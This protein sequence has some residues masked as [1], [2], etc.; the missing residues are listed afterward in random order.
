MESMAFVPQSLRSPSHAGAVPP[1]STQ[2]AS[3]R[4]NRYPPKQQGSSPPSESATSFAAKALAGAACGAALTGYGRSRSQRRCSMPPRRRGVHV[5]AASAEALTAVIQERVPMLLESCRIND[6]REG[7]G[8]GL[9]ATRDIEAGEVIC[10]W[11]VED[12]NTVMFPLDGLAESLDTEDYGALAFE[13]LKAEREPEDSGWKSWMTAGVEAPPSHWLRLLL[14]EPMKV[15]DIWSSTT[16]GEDISSMALSIRDDLEELGENAT[17]EEWTAALSVAMS[18]C[19]L[20]D[21][22]DRPVLVLGLDML[23]DSYDDNVVATLEYE[24]KGGLLGLGVGGG[25]YDKI[26]EV[27]LKA[28]RDILEGEELLTRYLKKPHAGGYLEKYGFIPPRLLEEIAEGA[29]MLSFEPVKPDDVWYDEK[30]R[31]LEERNW[32]PRPRDFLMAGSD[33]LIPPIPGMREDDMGVAE[34]ITQCLR[35]SNIADA[36]AFLLDA[37]FQANLWENMCDRISQ[38]NESRVCEDV[39]AECDRWIEKL[40]DEEEEVGEVDKEED[41]FQW[42]LSCL[43]KTEIDQLKRVKAIWAQ[44]LTDT[45]SDLSRPYW[46]DRQIK[47]VFP[48]LKAGDQLNV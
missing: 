35:F 4:C 32:T 14:T 43:R 28:D 12:T 20:F 5:R 13:L 29:V 19:V 47:K 2:R 23:Q 45:A 25:T 34:K 33:T 10:K 31:I 36:D 30:V 16:R 26:K 8:L 48:N 27:Q 15:K 41:E 7:E 21:P 1:H 38:E 9:F 40:E 17:L 37:V 22:D 11:D 6:S 18:R 3:L 39:M 42:M 46:V 24:T 44:E